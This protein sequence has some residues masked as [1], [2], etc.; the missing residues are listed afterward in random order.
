ML[1]NGQVANVNFAA[2]QSLVH[3]QDQNY[4]GMRNSNVVWIHWPGMRACGRNCVCMCACLCAHVVCVVCASVFMR[5]CACLYV[6]MRVLVR[7]CM[8]VS[9]SLICVC[10]GVSV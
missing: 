2:G 3:L 4:D 1:L 5:V 9:V 6:R 10:M 7:V 8:C